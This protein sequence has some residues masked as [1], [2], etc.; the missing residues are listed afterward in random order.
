M[1][2]ELYFLIGGVGMFLVGMEIM[3]AALRD[4]AGENL[5]NLLARFTTTPLRGVATGAVTTAVIQSSSATTVMTVGFVGA[6]LMTMPQALGILYGAN[7]GT[8][9]T[10]WMVSLLGFK[11]QLGNLAMALLFPAALADLLGRGMW[12]RIGRI[13]SGLC[14]LLI[15]LELMQFGMKDLTDVLTPDLL[16]GSN[17]VGLFALVGIGVLLTALMQSSSAAM[18]LALVLLEGGAISLVQAAMIVLGMNIGTTFT[19]LLAALSGSQPMRQTAV[20]N[21]GFNIITSI[22]AF[23]LLVVGR[24]FLTHIAETAGDMTALLVFHTGFNL[25]GTL[26]FLPFTPQFAR[27][28]QRLMPERKPASLISLDR[29]LL[30]DPGSALLAAQVA[31]NAIAQRLF[32]ALGSGLQI[33]PDLRGLAALGVCTEAIAELKEYLADIRLAAD[34][35]EQEEAFAALVHQTDHMLRLYER[36]QQ[37]ENID[38]LLHDRVLQR[39]AIAVGAALREAAKAGEDTERLERLSRL[40]GNRYKRHRRSLML[41]EHAGIYSLEDVF[42]HAD[43]MRWLDRS[44][45]HAARTKEYQA[46][47]EQ[48]APATA[49]LQRA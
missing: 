35:N 13:F 3:T 7:I 33:R 15:G 43:A 45:Y 4:A 11:L 26:I 6:G 18:A 22:L 25:V 1:A 27:L 46:R 36:C 29:N 37:R 10:G 2:E 48:G 24:T 34:N 32:G 12:A 20:A 40:V 21:L 49:K 41:G 16:P 8:T 30:T 9:A 39:P 38:T 31:A 23:P 17:I 14:L 19:A 28:V 5:R 42:H 44:L 47:V